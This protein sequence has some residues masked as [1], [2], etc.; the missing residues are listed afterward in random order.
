MQQSSL[1]P[2]EQVIRL[3]EEAG[4]RTRSQAPE[5]ETPINLLLPELSDDPAVERTDSGYEGEDAGTLG[6]LAAAVEIEGGETFLHYPEP[7]Q[8]VTGPWVV[9]E[10]LGGQ[11]ATIH[12]GRGVLFVTA[13][14]R[15]QS[16]DNEAGFNSGLLPVR[17]AAN[18]THPIYP[19]DRAVFAPGLPTYRVED[20][21]DGSEA[22]YVIYNMSVP[23]GMSSE[24]I[25]REFT[26]LESVDR[27]NFSFDVEPEEASPAEPLRTAVERAHETVVGDA[28]YG[29]YSEPTR[30]S[31][32]RTENKIAVGL[33]QQGETTFSDEQY[34]LMV[35]LLSTA[36]ENWGE[37]Q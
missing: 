27:A 14:Y 36:V 18:P 2:Y 17:E 10:P 3:A 8:E 9:L 20:I 25:E 33:G 7:I 4:E 12:K 30:F 37:S 28:L 35:E 6:R 19:A 21:G 24:D 32:L 22:Q 11:I 1:P 15:H 23:L 29:W 26:K 5:V 13:Q 34:G 16:D 31:T